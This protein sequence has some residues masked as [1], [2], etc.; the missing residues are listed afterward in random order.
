MYPALIIFSIWA[1]CI[2]LLIVLLFA[3]V[4]AFHLCLWFLVAIAFACLRSQSKR[5]YRQDDDQ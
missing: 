4:L 1:I 3:P 2:A 5:L